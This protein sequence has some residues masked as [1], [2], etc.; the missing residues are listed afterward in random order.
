MYIDDYYSL[1]GLTGL[2]LATAALE[3]ERS[4]GQYHSR[5]RLL[6]RAVGTSGCGSYDNQFFH[7]GPGKWNPR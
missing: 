2:G 4:L 7:V 6:R 1:D 5:F 3:R